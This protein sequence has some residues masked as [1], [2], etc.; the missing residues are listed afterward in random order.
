MEANEK[1]SNNSLG[2]I[3]ALGFASFFTDLSSEM[4][5]FAESVLHPSFYFISHISDFHQ[6]LLICSVES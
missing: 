6:Y 3:L 1:A 5:F 2:N 4:V